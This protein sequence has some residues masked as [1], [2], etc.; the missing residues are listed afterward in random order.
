MFRTLLLAG[1]AAGAV[2]L[3]P[4]TRAADPVPPATRDALQGTTVRFADRAQGRAVLGAEDDW[5][6]ATS[7]LQRRL[8]AGRPEGGA[9]FRA[10]QAA[11]ALAWTP[12]G[13][14]RWQ[15][16]LDHIAPA[17]NR[18]RLPWPD[19]ILLV[20]TDGRESAHQPHT[21]GRAIMLPQ[22]FEQQGYADAE[23]LAHELWHVL[24][25]HQP[26]LA[27]RLYALIGYEPVAE[28]EWPRAWAGIRL[29]NP[30]APRHRHAMRLAIDGRDT[31]V[32]PV[33][34]VGEG[35]PHET[36]L[37]RIEPRLLE[38]LPGA[39]GTPTRARLRDGQPVWHEIDAVPAF[40]QRLGGNTDYTMDPE[41]TI[42]DNF[43]FLVV[44]RPVPNAGLLERIRGELGR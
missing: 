23:V 4:P 31:W 20:S 38:V 1:L 24:S 27:Q 17:L 41:E 36:L 28:L 34:V 37:D 6:R 10:A 11:S 30:D 8:L 2:A 7:P 40:L 13:R 39:D 32:V 42:A 33:V 35:G 3:A 21:R 12:A 14:A 22:R 18:L 15:A 5:T 29:A 43:M 26:A 19:E 44:G 25:R 9:R 16:A